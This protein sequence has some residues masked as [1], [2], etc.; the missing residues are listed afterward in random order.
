M[1]GDKEIAEAKGEADGKGGTKKLSNVQVL[2]NDIVLDETTRK[3]KDRFLF[4]KEAAL[5]FHDF[6]TRTKDGLYDFKISDVSVN[7]TKKSITL[8]N[9]SFGSAMSKESFM[10]H[11]KVAK[12]MYGLS[13]PTVTIKGVDWWP[14]I[15]GE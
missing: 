6:N 13:L 9:L 12:E 7:A 4:A 14:A 5:D 10:K 11:Q 1:E 15:N 8:K 2:M 3:D